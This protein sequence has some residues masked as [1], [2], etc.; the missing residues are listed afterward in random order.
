MPTTSAILIAVIPSDIDPSD[1][2]SS[3]VE[4]TQLLGGLGIDVVHEILAE[5]YGETIEVRVRGTPAALDRL[6]ARLSPPGDR[7]S[8]P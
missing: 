1:T 8:R 4:L 5:D 2:R 3:R 7:R 6:A